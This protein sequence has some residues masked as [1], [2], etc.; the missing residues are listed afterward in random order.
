MGSRLPPGRGPATAPPAP[1]TD[2][3]ELGGGELLD[4]G[5]AVCV[6][7]GLPLSSAPT[8]GKRHKEEHLL[9]KEQLKAIDIALHT[10]VLCYNAV[11]VTDMK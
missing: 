4:S 7:R 10:G 5:A 3:E 9:F 2:G 6:A 11:Q 1:S 8:S